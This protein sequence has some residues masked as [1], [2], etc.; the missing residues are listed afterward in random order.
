M[1][2]HGTVQLL[3]DGCKHSAELLRCERRQFEISAAD[4]FAP[5]AL[6]LLEIG[7]MAYL[8][9]VR[10]SAARPPL[11]ILTVE[12]E[13]GF[14]VDEVARFWGRCPGLVVGAKA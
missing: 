6:L 11:H 9:V 7:N 14:N 13:Q 8:G 1:K 5:G 12:M 3:P 10:S 2:R 4:P